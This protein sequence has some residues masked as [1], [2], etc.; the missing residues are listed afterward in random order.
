V[1]IVAAHGLSSFSSYQCAAAVKAVSSAAV[2]VIHAVTQTTAVAVT[3]AVTTHAVAKFKFIRFL[4]KGRFSFC[5]ITATRSKISN[6]GVTMSKDSFFV[7]YP[8]YIGQGGILPVTDPFSEN[9]KSKSKE[10][11]DRFII[12]E[13]F[14]KT[15]KNE[16]N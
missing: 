12:N 11:T 5:I 3:V 2:A 14:Q 6:R 7:R 13:N 1:A 4:P 16:E 9:Q 8:A 15:E 10:H